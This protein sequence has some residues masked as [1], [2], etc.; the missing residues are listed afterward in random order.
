MATWA[1][2]TITR[3]ISDKSERAFL[4]VV[5]VCAIGTEVPRPRSGTMARF[6]FHIR[7]GDDLDEDE[8]GFEFTSEEDAR[9]EALRAAR[10]M[11]AEMIEQNEPIH[12][13]AFI[14]QDA[15]RRT[16]ALVPFLSVIRIH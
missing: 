5:I 13:T 14:L 12:E 4:T 8:E 7:Y 1:P 16:V 15:D 10:E 9:E 11:V 3:R 2:P 6:Y